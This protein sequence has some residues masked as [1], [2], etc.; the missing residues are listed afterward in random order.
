VNY[1]H[2]IVYYKKRAGLGGK[3]AAG[4]L[5]V[6]VLMATHLE[7]VDYENAFDRML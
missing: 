5:K 7:L 3:L 2:L 6:T 4:L 1:S